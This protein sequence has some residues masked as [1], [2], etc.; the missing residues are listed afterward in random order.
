VP[1]KKA[2]VP[3]RGRGTFAVAPHELLDVI[4]AKKTFAD[5]TRRA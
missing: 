1:V 2:K 5:L 3:M 4:E